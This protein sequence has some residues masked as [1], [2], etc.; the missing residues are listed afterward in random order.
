MILKKILLQRNLRREKINFLK[1]SKLKS[2]RELFL[3]QI[4]IRK[5][6]IH[7]NLVHRKLWIKSN[8]KR[9]KILSWSLKREIITLNRTHKILI[10]ELLIGLTDSAFFEDGFTGLN[11]IIYLF[12]YSLI[13]FFNFYSNHQIQYRFKR[14]RFWSYTISVKSIFRFQG[15]WLEHFIFLCETKF[16]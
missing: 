8:H 6:I 14:I 11:P 13:C 16:N 3:K 2:K 15:K 1:F 7:S 9:V 12:I 5:K 4:W 10:E